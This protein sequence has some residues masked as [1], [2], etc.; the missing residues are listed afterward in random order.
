MS[1]KSYRIFFYQHWIYRIY[2]WFYPQ[3]NSCICC[4]LTNKKDKPIII[5]MSEELTQE[6]KDGKKLGM[7]WALDLDVETAKEVITNI[8]SVIDR[9]ETWPAK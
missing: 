4:G 6:H 2:R 7:F 1:E 5:S 9:V 8:Q 3:I